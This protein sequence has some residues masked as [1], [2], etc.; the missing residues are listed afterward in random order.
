MKL[1]TLDNIVRSSLLSNGLTIH[2][3]FD[4]LHS[5]IRCLR[6][7]NLDVLRNVKP[8]NIPV[9][10]NGNVI[11]PPDFV[12]YVRIGFQNGQKISPMTQDNDLNNL[13]NRNSTGGV[14][15]YPPGTSLSPYDNQYDWYYGNYFWYFNGYNVYDEM[16]GGIYGYKGSQKMSFKVLPGQ[17]R[18]QINQ[19]YT[20]TSVYMDY[21]SDGFDTYSCSTATVVSIYAIDIIEKYNTWQYYKTN[22]TKIKMVAIAEND[23][24]T[25]WERL[26]ARMNPFSNE[27][28]RSA[29]RKG[30]VST[31]KAF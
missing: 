11:L 8:V 9:D 30:Y 7:L 18:I 13:P 5:S 14:I 29:F 12:D 4:F 10:A 25:A 2:W 20:G 15:P 17:C 21:I 28:M 19:A 6:E 23:Y 3:Y 22:P 1:E 26:I 31:P 16:L 27:D 24:Y